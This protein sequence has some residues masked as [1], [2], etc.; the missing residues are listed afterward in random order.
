GTGRDGWSLQP[1]GQTMIRSPFITSSGTYPLVTP[2]SP[3]TGLW[4]TAIGILQLRGTINAQQASILNGITPPNS[5][6]VP[7]MLTDAVTRAQQPLVGAVLP[8]VPAIEE[9]Y[10]ESFELGWTGL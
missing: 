10:T 1:G 9:S 6:Q 5:T 7:W 4:Q 3:G 2:P 8:D